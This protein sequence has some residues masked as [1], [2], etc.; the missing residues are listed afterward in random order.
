MVSSLKELVELAHYAVCDNGST[1]WDLAGGRLL[2]TTMWP[3]GVLDAVVEELRTLL[4]HSV[5]ALETSDG[6][7][8]EVGF[9]VLASW[10]VDLRIREVQ[11]LSADPSASKLMVLC[12]DRDPD[13]LL[14]MLKH[15]LGSRVCATHSGS[16]YVELCPPAANKGAALAMV[17]DTLGVSAKEVVAFGDMPNDLEMLEWAGVGVA[18]GNAHPALLAVADQVALSNDEDGFAACI[19]SL[20]REA[21]ISGV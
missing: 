16:P 1:V 5:L 20:L 18:M 15:V 10:R 9:A 8:A 21:R 7:I 14:E 17:C 19:R 13:L 3:P 6:T 11:R 4:P 12:D 2:A